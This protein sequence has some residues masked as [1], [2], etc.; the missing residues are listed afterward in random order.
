MTGLSKFKRKLEREAAFVDEV[1]MF[2]AAAHISR[3]AAISCR[4]SWCGSTRKGLAPE[5]ADNLRRT[6]R[7]LALIQ[8]LRGETKPKPEHVASSNLPHFAAVV[9]GITC[10]QASECSVVW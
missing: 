10:V 3:L 8:V 7:A 5:P 2:A 9:R 1:R 6:R 4:G